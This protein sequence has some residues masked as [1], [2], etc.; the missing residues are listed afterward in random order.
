[1]FRITRI[2]V[3]KFHALKLVTKKYYCK[4]TVKLLLRTVQESR[5]DLI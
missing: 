1:L 3:L 2:N 5:V 4:P